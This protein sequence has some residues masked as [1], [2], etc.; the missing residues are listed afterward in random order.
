MCPSTVNLLPLRHLSNM[1]LLQVI[2]FL[3]FCSFAYARFHDEE[4]SYEYRRPVNCHCDNSTNNHTLNN[5]TYFSANNSSL[6]L[7]ATAYCHYQTLIVGSC[8]SLDPSTCM[9]TAGGC[10]YNLKPSSRL[11]HNVMGHYKLVLQHNHS[12]SE[13]NQVVCGAIHRQGLLCRQCK[14][15]YGLALY[16]R[17]LECVECTNLPTA[18]MWALYL[19]LELLPLPFFFLLVVVM[20]VQ[21]ATPPLSAFVFYCQLFAELLRSNPY[22]HTIIE[23]HSNTFLRLLTL[24]LV[25]VWNLSF[26]RHLIPTFC[27]SHDVDNLDSIYLDFAFAVFPLLF[28]LLV[29]VAMEMHARDVKVIVKLWRP[30]HRC[31]VSCRRTRNPQASMVNAFITFAILSMNKLMMLSLYSIYPVH[32]FRSGSNSTRSLFI[33]PLRKVG[34][35]PQLI[36]LFCMTFLC[37]VIV[38]ITLNIVYPMKCLRTIP[39]LRVF[40]DNQTLTYFM[41]AWQGHFK[42]RVNS[43]TCCDYRYCGILFFVHRLFATLFL[44]LRVT[45]LD[46]SSSQ[47]YFMVT[48][49]TCMALFY[50]L[51]R[52]YTRTKMN[53]LESLLL[54]LA[55]IVLSCTFSLPESVVHP[56]Y[57]T[58]HVAQRADLI[59]VAVLFPSLVMLMVVVYQL[60]CRLLV[61]CLAVSTRN[62]LIASAARR[63]NDSRTVESTTLPDRLD[64]PDQ[65]TPLLQH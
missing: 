31:F 36:V 22:L 44:S 30:F 63:R 51:A 26:F 45:N 28:V 16:A 56:N 40:Y 7:T 62:G 38:P 3:T 39:C 48:Y 33:D 49:L 18:L 17:K 12:C 10:P 27:V 42:N 8:V 24:T 2:A 50:A 19:L 15:G 29:Y 54:G 32:L 25:D 47:S 1:K 43:G 61:Q 34:E 11:I 41:E 65:Y 20:D 5:S 46:A 37:L 14:D 58:A 21:V 13:V 60:V 53:I 57:T 59:L 6:L 4:C 55:V 52:P 9:L 64:H 35:T 23:H